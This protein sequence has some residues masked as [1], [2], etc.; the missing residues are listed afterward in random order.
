M[1]TIKLTQNVAIFLSS[2]IASV[3]LKPTLS[4]I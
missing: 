2:Y 4:V 1:N 3:L